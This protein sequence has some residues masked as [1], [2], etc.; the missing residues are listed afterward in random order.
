MTR[1]LCKEKYGINFDGAKVAISSLIVVQ[2]FVLIAALIYWNSE[3]GHHI[4]QFDL[5]LFGIGSMIG[6]FRTLALIWIN[7]ALTVGPPPLVTSIVMCSTLLFVVIEAVRKLKVPS[8][9]EIICLVIGF[10][11]FFELVMPQY[12]ERVLCFCCRKKRSQSPSSI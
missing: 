11:G 4:A 7:K 12:V 5:H 10:T 2:L 8:F 9:I 6:V 1:F 3:M